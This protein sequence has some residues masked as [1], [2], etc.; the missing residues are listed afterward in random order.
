[1]PRTALRAL[2]LAAL[3]LLA[4]C[5]TPQE[6]CIAR[7]TR[8]LRILDRL[9]AETEGNIARGYALEEVTVWREYWTTC[10]VAQAPNP[11]GTARPPVP[12]PCERERAETQTRA[13][14]IDLNVERDKLRS[15]QTK[16][17]DLAQ[18]AARS[19]AACRAAHP[20]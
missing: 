13:K 5:G 14:A 15:M 10:L 19:V 16:R 6:R 12:Q 8:E 20:E 18:A 4:A 9:I 7:E 11:D 1:M 3:A 2:P 17:R